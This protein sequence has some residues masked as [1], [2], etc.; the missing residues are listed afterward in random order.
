M[1]EIKNI[2]KIFDNKEILENINLKIPSKT[3]FGL[4]GIN[5]AGK[6]TLLRII[7][8]IYKSDEGE[9]LIDGNSVY[10]NEIVKKDIFFVSD[11]L[12]FS[13]NSTIESIKNI[14]KEFYS[15][16]NSNYEK[17]LKLFKLN[18]KE[19]IVNY[20]KGMKRQVALLMALS[21][22]PK[23]LL[24]DEA[25][26]GLDPLIRMNFKKALYELMENNSIII[27]SSH[28]L[29]ELEDLC[30]F[31]AILDNSKIKTSGQMM[32]KLSEINKYQ[33]AFSDNKNIED[34]YNFEILDFKKIGK[35]INV[36]IKGD[37]KEIIANL[38]KMQPILLEV[39]KIG[40]E[41][42]FI[43]EVQGDKNV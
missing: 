5:G 17:Y 27:I 35:V 1:I 39:L 26:D 34:F 22:K 18:P 2:K 12:F 10:E 19:K 16:D 33:I 8:G 25:F 14:Y 13:R 37:K 6:S 32:E 9:V 29:R 30:D 43:Y 4:V 24:L 42:M 3:I 28:N 20:S 31:Y 7:S 41:E 23:V 40:F 11:E 38:E 21:I 36:V 15:F